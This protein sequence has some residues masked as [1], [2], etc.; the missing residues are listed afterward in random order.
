MSGGAISE[1]VSAFMTLKKRF[2]ERSVLETWKLVHSMEG[3]VA[4]I[5]ASIAKIENLGKSFGLSAC[6]VHLQLISLVQK[7]ASS[8]CPC[9]VHLF[10]VCSGTLA[11]YVFQRRE[12][13][14]STTSSLGCIPSK[15]RTEVYGCMVLLGPAK[16]R[17]ETPSLKYLMTSTAFWQV[18]AS[19]H[20]LAITL[21]T[22]SETLSP[23]WPD[24]TS[25]SARR[26]SPPS[27]I[28][29]T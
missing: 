1:F 15:I 14:S 26:S 13:D 25:H 23:R 21:A 16:P 19:R 27:R 28:T 7:G 5:G 24:I 11:I 8:C 29:A 22:Y 17:S 9:L 20:R 2:E 4:Q 18:F 3:G 12:R 6:R 10:P